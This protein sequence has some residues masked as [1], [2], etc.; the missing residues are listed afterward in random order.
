MADVPRQRRSDRRRGLSARRPV[1]TP[2]DL[3]SRS[4][5]R[6]HRRD[7][8]RGCLLG[9]MKGDLLAID[10]ATGKPKWRYKATGRDRGR[11]GDPGREAVLRHQPGPLPRRQRRDRREALDLRGRRPDHRLRELHRRQRPLRLLRPLP[12]LP[13]RDTGKLVWKFETDAELHASPCIADGAVVIGGC[14]AQLRVIDAGR[15]EAA[16]HPATQLQ[17]RIVSR[18]RRQAHLRLDLRQPHVLRRSFRRPQGG[19]CA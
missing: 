8:G 16:R 14:D 12:L 15:R 9:T 10:L 7:P 2:L 1:E 6:V 17:C 18:L 4:A 19:R 13:R 5:H 11:A 3:R